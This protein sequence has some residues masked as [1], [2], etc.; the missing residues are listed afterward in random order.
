MRAG[1]CDQPPGA[2]ME[3]L[4]TQ[5][6]ASAMLVLQ[7]GAAEQTAQQQITRYRLAQQQQA[8][9]ALAIGIVGDEHI[10]PGDRLESGAARRLVKLYQ[11]EEIV[12]VGQRQCRHRIP[13]CGRNCFVH[14]HHAIRN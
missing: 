4:A 11:A 9:W 5:L 14:A 2:L 6:G 3:P 1:Q 10:A 7:I 13:L 8:I 12:Q